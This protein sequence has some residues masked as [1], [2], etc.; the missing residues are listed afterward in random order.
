M[1]VSGRVGK[2]DVYGRDPTTLVPC[3]SLPR[4]GCGRDLPVPPTPPRRTMVHG[5][6]Y[7]P[8]LTTRPF[9]SPPS[10]GD[11]WAPRLAVRGPQ[12]RSPAATLW[13]G[14]TWWSRVPL[15][16]GEESTGG[17]GWRVPRVDGPLQG[18]DLETVV[19]KDPVTGRVRPLSVSFRRRGGVLSGSQSGPGTR[20]E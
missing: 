16:D 10:P 17:R 14:R 15:I 4:L 6:V 11:R 20:R 3:V 18:W 13:F 12:E 8:R 7:G 5:H 9:R 1:G 2:K 19:P